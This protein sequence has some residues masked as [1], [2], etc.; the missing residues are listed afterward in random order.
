[1]QPDALENLFPPRVAAVS[2]DAASLWQAALHPDE[3]ALIARAA[4]ARQREFAVG[5][6]C[7]REALARLGIQVAAITRTELRAPAWPAGATGSITHCR[8]Y[9]AAV[10]APSAEFAALGIDAERTG[11]VT[12]RIL[13]RV[14]T[15]DERA[16][17][18]AAPRVQDSEHWRTLVWCAKESSLKCLASATGRMP[19]PSEIAIELAPG[20]FTTRLLSPQLSD[21]GLG[22]LYGRTARLDDLVLAGV[23][24]ASKCGPAADGALP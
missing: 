9:C 16:A 2:A 6:A 10:A 7:A 17:F 8:A 14:T 11:R 24:I 4:P 5:R 13:E 21:T 23:T 18:P 20:R 1:M 12:A 22:E 19:A 3:E 15:R